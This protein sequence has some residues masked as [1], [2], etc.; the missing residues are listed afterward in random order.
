MAGLTILSPAWVLI[1]GVM[2]GLFYGAVSW[3]LLSNLGVRFMLNQPVPP[4][5][6]V[7]VKLEFDDDLGP[8]VL[9]QVRG[10]GTMVECHVMAEKIPDLTYNGAR[11]VKGARVVVVTAPDLEG[12]PQEGA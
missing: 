6:V 1:L 2:L 4:Q 7:A 3:M 12:Q 10:R 11:K 8:P 5:Y 9:Y